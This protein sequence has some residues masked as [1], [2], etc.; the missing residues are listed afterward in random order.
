MILELTGISPE[1][2]PKQ[3]KDMNKINSFFANLL[4]ALALSLLA[5][6][7][8]ASDY[9]AA[10]RAGL[11]A[12]EKAVKGEGVK[13]YTPSHTNPFQ[14]GKVEETFSAQKPGCI[15]MY[16]TR[17]DGSRGMATVAVDKGSVKLLESGR[18]VYDLCHN[19]VADYV[20]VI[21]GALQPEVSMSV[22]G[23]DA[24]TVKPPICDSKCQAV[25]QCDI[26]KGQLTEENGAWI[27]TR[28]RSLT[29]VDDWVVSGRVE[30]K[31]F[32]W[33]PAKKLEV[34][35]PPPPEINITRGAAPVVTGQQCG[36]VACDPLQTG[37]LVGIE[38]SPDGVCR[39]VARDPQGTRHLIAF[40]KYPN[41]N[42]SAI[43]QDKGGKN[44]GREMRLPFS[45]SDCRVI[46]KEVVEKFDQATKMS[47]WHI[48]R[49][50]LGLPNLCTI[51]KGHDG[52]LLTLNK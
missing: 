8:W 31:F 44:V 5:S 41:D 51:E 28:K 4:A 52:R 25:S 39:I 42:L 23:R 18:K 50:G 10:S 38:P 40:G 1:T 16:V 9:W 48:V 27:C 47:V 12:C 35:A 24:L 21:F 49:E 34:P 29:I 6:G 37:R 33:T 14:T 22:T 30:S 15:T 32:S 17:E 45:F 19:L 13:F 11:Q 43:L 3:E 36:P 46:T 20:A 2:L 7:A 26:E